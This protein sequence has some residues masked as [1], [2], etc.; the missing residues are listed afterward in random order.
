MY[1]PEPLTVAGRWDVLMTSGILGS[2][3][4]TWGRPHP[5]LVD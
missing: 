2:T 5:I 3:L 1:I 4:G